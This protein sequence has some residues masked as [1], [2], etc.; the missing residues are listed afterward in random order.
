MIALTISDIMDADNAILRISDL[1]KRKT[2]VEIPNALC[3]R[4]DS[5]SPDTFAEM[6]Q[7]VCT[8]WDGDVILESVDPSSLTKAAIHTIGRN[9]TLIGANSGNLDE[10]IMVA[11]M[12]NCSL[13]V[14]DENIETL[15]DIAK[16]AKDSGIG[17]IFVDPMMRNMK[18][19]LERCTD[20]KRIKEIIP[21]LDFKIAVRSWS[22]E[23]A[24]TMATV[25]LMVDDALVIVDDL[26]WDSCYTLS[27]LL[28]SIR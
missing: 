4:N 14:S 8:L 21:D 9:T 19:C 20:I 1:L 27:A 15:F 12:F 22:G 5:F 24:M 11:R 7:L 13:C 10:F 23:Y 6:T 16:T 25:S 26:D 2:S 28:S 17:T 18:Q 3:I